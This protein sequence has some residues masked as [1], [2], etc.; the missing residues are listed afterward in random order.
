MSVFYS[1]Q[2]LLVEELGDA[3]GVDGVCGPGS[4]GCSHVNDTP[5]TLLKL[6]HGP[7][8]FFRCPFSSL[9]SS[10]VPLR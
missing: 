10:G 7:G 9:C 6:S 4:G 3:R 2:R 8:D 5:I 1:E